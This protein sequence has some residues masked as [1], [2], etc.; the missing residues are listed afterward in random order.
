MIE[1]FKLMDKKFTK[2][3]FRYLTI[4]IRF[5][6]FLTVLSFSFSMAQTGKLSGV[7]LLDDGTP[8]IRAHV[9]LKDTSLVTAT[10]AEGKFE[11]DNIRDGDYR[12][13]VSYIGFELYE[14]PVRVVGGRSINIHVKL[15]PNPTELS[16]V[17][18][19]GN[20][21]SREIAS[22]PITVSSVDI[23]TQFEK[24]LSVT[25]V[26][27][28]VSGVRVRNSGGAGSTAD[29]SINGMRGNAVRL[30]VDGIP[31][32][33]VSAGLNISQIPL[34][35]I[36]RVDVYK[37]VIPVEIGTDALGGGINI[38]SNQPSFNYLRASYRIGSFNT[39]QGGLVVGTVNKKQTAY[40]NLSS[41][42]DYSDN[43][44]KMKAVDIISGK[45]IEA[46]RFN[47]QF[48]SFYTRASVGLMNK[49]FADDLQLT[50][51]YVKLYRQYQ[52]GLMVNTVPYGEADYRANNYTFLLKYDKTFIERMEVNTIS[53]YGILDY[54]FT[55]TTKNIYSWTGQVYDRAT[56]G[57]ESTNH[58]MPQFPHITTDGLV[59][60]TTLKYHIGNTG[61]FTLSNFIASQQ[62]KGYNPLINEGTG[63][64]DYLKRPHNMLKNISGL[65]YEFS[66]FGKKLTTNAS[67]KFYYYR[68]KGI[69]RATEHPIES[70][71]TRFGWNMSVKYDF[72]DGFFARTSYERATRI[73]DFGEVFGNN[74]TIV[75][76]LTLKPEESNNFNLGGAYTRKMNVKTL[77]A[78]MNGF[79]RQQTNRIFLNANSGIFSTYENRQSVDVKGL[80]ATIKLSPVKNLHATVNITYQSIILKKSGLPNM[81][82]QDGKRLP[83]EPVFFYN[84][85]LRYDLKRREKDLATLYLFYNHMDEFAYIYTGQQY[86]K[87]NYVPSQDQ[88]DAGLSRKFHQGQLTVSANIQNILDQELFDHYKVPR[89]GRSF[90]IQLIYE[91]NHFKL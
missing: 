88:L 4:K 55:D 60:R 72:T 44:Y 76:N 30:Y 9:S 49:K 2:V 35:A 20:S 70:S 83:N 32:E 24:K 80:E 58:S 48:M 84:A 65:Q 8:A 27:A 82:F 37:G 36:K 39:H 75:S 29:V 54:V 40:F 73:P 50:L 17:I 56:H 6:L 68:L 42:F 26:L 31:I 22:Q 62:Q 28:T 15:H 41:S 7:A 1:L 78:E 74:A 10:N 66:S 33:F 89:P 45:P 16:E 25:D 71:N 69:E 85:E 5:S 14:Q 90:N 3:R 53:S 77:Y 23:K 47:D 19:T 79:Y 52:N 87:D 86:N 43:N 12:L 59:N 13:I 11:F 38:V 18:V 67:G 91:L 46:E 64:I 81:Q 61:K 34:N 21:E 57:G 63:E 51:T